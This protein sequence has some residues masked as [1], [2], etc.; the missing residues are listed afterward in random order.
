MTTDLSFPNVDLV[1]K[2]KRRQEIYNIDDL[3]CLLSLIRRYE[4]GGE[5]IYGRGFRLD[6]NVT[7]YDYDSDRP[8]TILNLQTHTDV[9]WHSHPF[10]IQLMNA[11]PSLEDMIVS[12]N[13]ISLIF[14]IITGRG[15]YIISTIKEITERDVKDFYN[16]M[17]NNDIES[18]FVNYE[19]TEEIVESTG[20]FLS[21]IPL[22][23]I[24][25][26]QI[27]KNIS[28]IKKLKVIQTMI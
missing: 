11:Y 1:I 6:T 16:S 26:D 2:L 13:N 8:Y 10:G 28:F 15:V 3:L 19:F 27:D 21:C 4:L 20:I 7:C 25:L 12:M 23:L 18:T 9:V 17:D 24:S 14:I 5:Y 22:S